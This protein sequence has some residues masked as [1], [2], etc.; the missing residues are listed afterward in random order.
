MP[1]T[2]PAKKQIAQARKLFKKVCFRCGATNPIT[3]T[4]CRKC[5]GEQLRLKN[6]QL[7]LKK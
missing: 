2:D 1:I 7:G 4:R 5:R 6:R 3:A